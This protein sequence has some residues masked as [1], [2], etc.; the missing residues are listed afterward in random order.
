MRITQRGMDVEVGGNDSE[1]RE[2]R[3][4]D[5][6]N[7]EWK[8]GEMAVEEEEVVGVV[9]GGQYRVRGTMGEGEKTRGVKR[10]GG[11]WGLRGRCWRSL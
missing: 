2:Q 6:W 9:L 3:Y 8:R 11:A 4:N 7:G 1:G 10:R 5:G